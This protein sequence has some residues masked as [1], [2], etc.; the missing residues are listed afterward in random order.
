MI[1]QL[2]GIGLGLENKIEFYRKDI[3]NPYSVNGFRGTWNISDHTLIPQ[4]LVGYLQRHFGVMRLRRV[5][6]KQINE[7]LNEIWEGPGSLEK[8]FRLEEELKLS[9]RDIKFSASDIAKLKQVEVDDEDS[10]EVFEILLTD[11][12]EDEDD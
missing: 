12:V 11:A 2:V 5:P 9:G 10:D 6:M 8:I 7:L 4:T 1:E 3:D